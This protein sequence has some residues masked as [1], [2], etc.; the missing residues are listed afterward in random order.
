MGDAIDIY[1]INNTL[2]K[3]KYIKYLKYEAL[4]S[5]IQQQDLCKALLLFKSINI[6]YIIPD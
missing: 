5:T 3:F 2:V 4:N 6:Y 1:L